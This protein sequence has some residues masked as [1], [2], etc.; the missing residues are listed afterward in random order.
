MEVEAPKLFLAR[1]M[2]AMKLRTNGPT[3]MSEMYLFGQSLE[4]RFLEQL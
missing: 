2:L 3:V 4:T 1:I